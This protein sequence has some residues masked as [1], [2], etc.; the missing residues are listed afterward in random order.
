MSA[1]WF[2]P[3]L[4]SQQENRRRY[5]NHPVCLFAATLIGVRDNLVLNTKTEWSNHNRVS[6]PVCC[7]CK[8]PIDIDISRLDTLLRKE[9]R[10]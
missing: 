5:H 2:D 4:S 3:N 8:H 1:W 9:T 7:A 10:T 6:T